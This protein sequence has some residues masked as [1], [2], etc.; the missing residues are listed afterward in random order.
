MNSSNREFFDY[1]KKRPLFAHIYF[2]QHN[3]GDKN[4][5]Y[6]K[7]MQTYSTLCECNGVPGDVEPESMMKRVKNLQTNGYFFKQFITSASF[8]HLFLN[9]YRQ[10]LSRMYSKQ[11][12]S[13]KRFFSEL[14][15]PFV[16]DIFKNRIGTYFK[17]TFSSAGMGG[18]YKRF[19]KW[20]KQLGKELNHMIKAVFK[21]FFTSTPIEKPQ[22]TET[23][24]PQDQSQEQQ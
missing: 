16:E 1:V 23:D 12:I 22:P 20:Y 21:A 9:V 24:A 8:I 11:I 5:L 18:S 14:W 6:S 3:I 19:H 13:A 10:D 7:I 2:A 4:T 17:K 15:N